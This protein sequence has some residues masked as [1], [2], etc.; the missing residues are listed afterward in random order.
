MGVANWFTSETASA[1]KPI[2]PMIAKNQPR[3]SPSKNPSKEK[4]TTDVASA[5]SN[6]TGPR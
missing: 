1:E 4:N 5:V 3:Q 6:R 2:V